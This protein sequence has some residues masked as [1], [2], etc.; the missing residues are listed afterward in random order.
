MSLVFLSGCGGGDSLSL[1]KVSGVVNF[2]GAPLANATLMFYPESGP[3]GMGR[4]DDKG[5]FQVRTNGQLGAVAGVH[6]VTVAVAAEAEEA[7]PMDGKEMASA[8]K[9]ILPKKYADK[10]TTDIQITIPA[11]GDNVVI[12]IT[13]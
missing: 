9:S 1:E 2:K 10:E 12:D 3:A 11:P 13:E 6:K 7:P 8:G 5:A 4:S